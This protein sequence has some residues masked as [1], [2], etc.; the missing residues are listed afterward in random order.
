MFDPKNIHK[1]FVL[2]RISR[3]EQ[4]DKREKVGSILLHH[5]VAHMQHNL[6]QGLVCAVGSNVL[7][8]LPEIGLGDTALFSHVVEGTVSVTDNNKEYKDRNIID[9]SDPDY[10]YY[11][12][13]AVMFSNDTDPEGNPIGKPIARAQ[14]LYGC[15]KRHTAE[16]HMT[17]FY[18]LALASPDERD[19]RT[20]KKTYIKDVN[21]KEQVILS[22]VDFKEERK[23]IEDRLEKMK[24]EAETHP[25]RA[26]Q[27]QIEMEKLTRSLNR[28]RAATF[29]PVFS[30]PHWYLDAFGHPLDASWI[31]Y[32]T[33]IGGN[34]TTP[35]VTQITLQ[36]HSFY[37]LRNDYV[38]CARK[39][40][41]RTIRRLSG[42]LD[43]DEVLVEKV[44]LS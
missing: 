30:S 32:Y 15:I 43:E 24:M 31:L 27:L 40:D 39:M 8:I 4:R 21:G 1:D 5:S 29:V 6:Q 33:I 28:K 35:Q 38:L 14:L 11:M 13:H 7:K 12:V 36:N 44:L 9:D 34:Q 19:N 23:Q 22:F 42:Q 41:D 37:V 16:V 20:M 25:K 2:V 3:Q 26:E 17:I 10:R 18:T